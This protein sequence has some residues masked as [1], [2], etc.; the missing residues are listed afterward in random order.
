MNCLSSIPMLAPSGKDSLAKCTNVLPK[1]VPHLCK[2]RKPQRGACRCRACGRT[3]ARGAKRS[4]AGTGRADG[5]CRWSCRSGPCRWMPDPRAF[6]TARP[7]TERGA[8]A[9]RHD[10]ALAAE[11]RSRLF[12][13]IRIVARRRPRSVYPYSLAAAGLDLSALPMISARS[14]LYARALLSFFLSLHLVPIYL[15]SE[16]HTYPAEPCA[17]IPS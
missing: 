16:E 6:D 1:E 5:S 15:P 7:G 4:G 12:H 3:W 2:R 17:P 13:P 10:S 8:R 11:R 14:P 9:R